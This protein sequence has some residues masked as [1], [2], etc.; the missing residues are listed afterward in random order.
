M[1]RTAAA[2]TA[3][4][5]PPARG[6]PGRQHTPLSARC[7]L[8]G[9]RTRPPTSP[10]ARGPGPGA[11]LLAGEHS[12]ST[13]G[14]AAYSSTAEGR[15]A[16]TGL[17]QP[18]TSL[19][20][21]QSVSATTLPSEKHKVTAG[22]TDQGTRRRHATLP[23]A[24]SCQT[25]G[26]R[27]PLKRRV[28][29]QRPPG[30]GRS[31]C[32]HSSALSPRGGSGQPPCS[33]FCFSSASGKHQDLPVLSPAAGD[34]PVP[35]EGFKGC[36]PGLPYLL[37]H[38]L[39]GSGTGLGWL[40]RA[41]LRLSPC[42]AAALD[43]LCRREHGFLQ[44]FSFL[45]RGCVRALLACGPARCPHPSEYPPAHK[46]EGSSVLF[47]S[48]ISHLPLRRMP[49]LSLASSP[50]CSAP[51]RA[52]EE[53]GPVVTAQANRRPE[54]STRI[55]LPDLLSTLTLCT[56]APVPVATDWHPKACRRLCQG[57]LLVTPQK[58]LV[59]LGTQLPASL[60]AASQ[61][62]CPILAPAAPTSVPHRSQALRRFHRLLR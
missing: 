55:W 62:S 29:S 15:R 50:S 59:L 45:S 6:W 20:S 40:G 30:P 51:H 48:G 41:Q 47:L 32:L 21:P 36:L 27:S 22:A 7:C 28:S 60:L 46:E 16:G 58:A 8:G 5:R 24:G 12:C 33:T 57:P 31:L 56:A 44:H 39:L 11:G 18:S 61:T 23:W 38:L 9:A 25:P 42:G 26:T 34:A 35:R 54:C 4:Q 1:G 17:L 10:C 3:P 14:K 19:C 43:H 2:G 53:E 13:E 37:S 52:D 49:H